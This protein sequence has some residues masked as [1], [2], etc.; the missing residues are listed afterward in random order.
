MRDIPSLLPRQ[1]VNN[2]PMRTRNAKAEIP[3]PAIERLVVIT[4]LL[5]QR[6][7]YRPP[8]PAITECA[9]CKIMTKSSNKL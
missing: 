7:H 5:P 9:V 1:A 6:P 3:N 4:I 8:F 2:S